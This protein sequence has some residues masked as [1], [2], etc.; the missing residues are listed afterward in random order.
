[1][2]YLYM[3]NIIGILNNINIL[4]N[5]KELIKQLL[6]EIDIEKPMALVTKNP[7]GLYNFG[8]TCFHNSVAQLVYRMDSLRDF[9]IDDTIQNQYE[10]D[11]SMY[12]FINLLRQMKTTNQRALGREIL[13]NIGIHSLCSKV[14]PGYKRGQEDA[15]N[16]LGS[17][18]D[19]LKTEI[20]D[21]YIS[22]LF[23][24]NDPRSWIQINNE[25][26]EC[27][28]EY[29]PSNQIMVNNSYQFI[30]NTDIDAII[31]EIE[32]N[33]EVVVKCLNDNEYVNSS[34]FANILTL[35]AIDIKQHSIDQYINLIYQGVK[36]IKFKSTNDNP[37]LYAFYE[38]YKITPSKYFIINIIPQS[39]NSQRIHHNIKLA[40]ENNQIKINEKNYKMI[41]VVLQSGTVTGGHYISFIEYNNKWFRYNDDTPVSEI[42][43]IEAALNNEESSYFVP[44]IVLY[45][46]IN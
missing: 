6:I 2:C 7:P 31:N 28:T 30:D 43:D 1:M 24:V 12:R 41:G 33:E 20:K 22:Q 18:L 15:A 44:Y 11:S 4:Y 14:L 25:I 32:N 34:F 39:N 16:F 5:R 46:Q 27:P 17:L 45:E 13:E 38:K 29:I 26:G 19:K 8:A 37:M 36:R 3:D 9:L 42:N 35:N 23:D 10:K 40:N 21:E